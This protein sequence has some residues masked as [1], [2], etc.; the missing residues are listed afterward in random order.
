MD[1]QKNV[2]LEM[3]VGGG[4]GGKGDGWIENVLSEMKG[5]GGGG[6]GV[7]GSLIQLERVA[8]HKA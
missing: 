8:M 6:G 7:R 1:K 3:C 5:W 2:L 4:G